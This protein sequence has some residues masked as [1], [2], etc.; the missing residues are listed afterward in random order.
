VARMPKPSAKQAN[1]RTMSSTATR[2]P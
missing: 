2:L 1:T